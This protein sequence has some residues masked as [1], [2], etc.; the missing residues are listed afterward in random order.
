MK[1]AC[2]FG[3]HDWTKWIVIREGRY[4][5]KPVLVAVDT[6]PGGT[7]AKKDIEDG[8]GSLFKEQQRCCDSCGKLE[9]RTAYA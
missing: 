4:V 5:N 9:L 7:S 8:F 6:L 3:W 2:R 1:M